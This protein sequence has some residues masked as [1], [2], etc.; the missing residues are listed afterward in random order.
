MKLPRVLLGEELDKKLMASYE[1]WSTYVNRFVL[2][3]LAGHAGALIEPSKVAEQALRE[4]LDE[5]KGRLGGEMQ[6]WRWDRLHRAVFP[7]YP[8][9][10][11]PFLQKWFSRSVPC[12]GDWSTVNFGAVSSARP[13]IQRNVP[14]YR[15]IIDLAQPDG[16]SFIHSVGQSGHFLSPHY[17]DYLK[18]WAAVRYRPMRFTREAVERDARA[19]LRLMPKAPR[20]A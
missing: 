9:H 19:T 13:F 8:F 15:Q 7:H 4:A 2:N 3:S 11:L 10:N 12:G 18:D 16:G 5:L 14:G 1:G 6:T 17:D 20:T